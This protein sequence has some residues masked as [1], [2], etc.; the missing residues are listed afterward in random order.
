MAEDK[1]RDVYFVFLVNN[2]WNSFSIIED[3][4]ATF[5]WVYFHF[6]LIHFPVPLVIV[7]CINKYLVK[8]FIETRSICDLFVR[9]SDLS[10]WKDPLLLF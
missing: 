2:D 8:D 9:E 6:N 3:S 5:F 1:L 10:L 7:G 4:N